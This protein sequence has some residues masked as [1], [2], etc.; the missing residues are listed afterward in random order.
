VASPPK[1]GRES[2]LFRTLTVPERLRLRGAFLQRIRTY[3]LERGFT[4]VETPVRVLSPGIDPHVDALPA[5]KGR[6]LATSPE[7]EMKKLLAAGM[8]RIFQITRAFRD[9]EIGQIHNP[10]FTILEWYAA[11]QTYLD[12]MNETE[13][14][15]M[16]AGSV[17]LEEGVGTPLRSWPRPFPR[18]TVDEAF[19]R[20][21]GWEPSRSFRG[22]LFFE[23]LV[24][25]VEPALGERRAVFLT[26]YP[27]PVGALARR[28]GEDMMVCERFELYLEGVEIC[29]GFS[30]LTDPAEQRERFERDNRE[31]RRLGKEAYPVD[32]SFLAALEGG[33]PPC[34][35]NALGVDRLLLA[36]TG[37]RRLSEV[38]LLA[39]GGSAPPA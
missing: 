4:E 15:V 19:R 14:L 3:F 33:L 26:D 22:D 13:T 9:G 28:K 24:N 29:N 7:L 16:D 27:E 32:S 37:L 35:G 25:K 5:G 30:E 12:L 10:E 21:A 8:E 2:R 31:R 17:L 18:M 11:G 23:D 20:Y 38:T 34:A 36:L 1:P 39:D 6:Y